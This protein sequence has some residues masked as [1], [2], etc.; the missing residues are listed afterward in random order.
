VNSCLYHL[1]SPHPGA[2]KTESIL[3]VVAPNAWRVRI[4]KMDHDN[5]GHYGA[6]ATYDLIRVKFWWPDMFSS[7]KKY[8]DTCGVC[9][10]V[11]QPRG[12]A[13]MMMNIPLKFNQRVAIDPCGPYPKTKNGNKYVI[14]MVECFSKWPTAVPVKRIDSISVYK[15]FING[16]VYTFG[17]KN[18]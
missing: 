6:T 1:W 13:P 3:Q 2:G 7:I 11:K 14:M 17:L 4:M 18:Y 5:A 10:S 9:E 15:E 8:V 16:Y 12:S